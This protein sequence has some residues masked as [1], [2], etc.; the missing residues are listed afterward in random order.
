MNR[1]KE[2]ALKNL[3]LIKCHCLT[4]WAQSTGETGPTTNRKLSAPST[5]TTQTAKQLPQ[6][7]CDDLAKPGTD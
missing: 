3:P 4:V 6:G 1:I 7:K 5:S 2:E